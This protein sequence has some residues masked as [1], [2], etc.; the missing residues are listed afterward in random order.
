MK[1][2]CPMIMITRIPKQRQLQRICT[3]L[4]KEAKER[5]KIIDWY[6]L[7]SKKYSSTGKPD[8]KLTCRH[9]GI[10]RSYFYY[11]YK[12]FK[13]YYLHSLDNKTT[14]P[15]KIKKAEYDYKL[16]STIREIRKENP[17]Y[18]C[19]KIR[20]ILLREDKGFKVPSAATIGRII[21]KYNMFY[22]FD[23]KIKSHKKASKSSKKA[24]RERLK[25][26]LKS[27]KPNTIIEFDMKHINLMNKK[28]YAM[29][30][31]DICT[32]RVI[33]HICSSPSSHNAI[34]ALNKIVNKFGNKIT[35]VNDNGSENMGE[36]EE[37]LKENNIKQL[38]ARVKVPKDKPHIERFIGTMQREFLD[39]HYEPYN[40]V[41][42]QKDINKWINKYETYRPHKSLNLLTPVEYENKLLL[43]KQILQRVS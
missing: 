16:V 10:Y 20:A 24:L 12:R 37:W 2:G 41:E 21:K 33:V 7:E 18:D 28:V 5:L 35:I 30:G 17:D 4:S 38:W 3:D 34:V 13:P 25:Y 40:C 9:F 1:T 11:W 8:V 27:D 43:S 15:K 36:A 39:Y 23:T 29:C 42:L 31:I 19:I 22:R 6:R 26:H 14:R 32:K